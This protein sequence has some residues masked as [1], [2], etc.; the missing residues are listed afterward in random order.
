MHGMPVVIRTFDLGAD[1]QLNQTKRVANNPAL[2]RRAI[3]LSLAEPQMFR[4]Q[5]R[6]LLRVT[7]YGNVK[8][9]VPM[10][11]SVTEIQQTLQFIAHVKQELDQ[12]GIAYNPEVQIGGMIE[13]PAAALALG[14]FIRKL[15]FL[16]IGT[17]DLIQYTLAID[18]TD[19]EVAHLYDPL[20]PAILQLL[21]HVISKANK[22]RIPIA[23]CGEMAGETIYTRLL[24]G[25]GLRQF[26]MQASQLLGVKQRILTT[27]VPEIMPLV[28][29]MLR[30][31]D[32][33]RIRE[34]LGRVN[35]V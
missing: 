4:T 17:N 29:K 28:Q 22:A 13:I 8:L 14:A 33:G 11:S 10:L 19:E 3:R 31:D 21:H 16:S 20:H 18:R 26:S 24:L 35:A 30:A 2:G 34:L 15:D 9:L 12:Q 25:L 32:P 5:I 1:K 27:G 7:Q 6:A 23:V